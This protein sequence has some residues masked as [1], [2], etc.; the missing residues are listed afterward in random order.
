MT[1]ARR[2]LLAGAGEELRTLLDRVAGGMPNVAVDEADS[3]EPQ[4]LNGKAVA[5]SAML[6]ELD[7]RSPSAVAAFEK[8]AGAVGDRKVIAAVRNAEAGDVR[9]LFRAGAADVL[10]APFTPATLETALAELI[11][12]GAPEPAAGGQIITFLKAGGGVGATTAAINLA[13]LAA[14]GEPKQKRPGRR[15]ALL[16]LDLQFGDADIALNLEPRSTLLDVIRGQNRFDGRF[17]QGA[18]TDHGS[19]LRLLAAAQ[20][21][22]PLDAL[23][24]EFAGEILRQ[25]AR[26]HERTFVDLPMVWTDWTLNVLR[27]SHLVVLVTAPTVQGALGARRTLDALAEAQLA[28]PSLLVLNGI[29][30]LVD[31]FE[32]PSRI[33]RSLERSID[34]VLGHDPNATRALDRG[35]PVIEAFPNTRLARD[36]RGLAQKIEQRLTQAEPQ[37]QPTIGAVA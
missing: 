19:G 23:S 16:D 17:L 6:V 35:A 26:L 32:K 3:L 8:L 30:G 36:L 5:S 24:A 12:A 9:R 27:A 31:G 15:T 22:V 14:R 1:K 37:Q 13:A 34:A 20:K 29:A 7:L 33:S 10:T 2:I 4:T 28:A 21:V 25:S 18:M 11:D